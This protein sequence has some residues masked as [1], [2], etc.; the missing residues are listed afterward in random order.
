[1]DKKALLKSVVEYYE[2]SQE[3]IN[4]QAELIESVCNERKKYIEKISSF[5]DHSVK[6]GEI[7]E[8][9]A[10]A[11]KNDLGKNPAKFVD[12]VVKRG[13][14]LNGKEDSIGTPSGI[15]NK[16]GAMSANDK[17]AAWVYS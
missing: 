2:S 7:P 17:L 9:L 8:Y 12:M 14:S 6:L 16:Q 1:M 15:P 4:K 3:T 11:I 5:I 10:D 13:F